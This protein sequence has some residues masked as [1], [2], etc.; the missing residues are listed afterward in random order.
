MD[1]ATPVHGDEGRTAAGLPDRA[2]PP[3][4]DGG[5]FGPRAVGP[6]EGVGEV[7]A[8]VARGLRTP[9]AVIVTAADAL[10]HLLSLE[11]PDRADVARVAD[12]ISRHSHLLR[13]LVARLGL[14]DEIG[15]GTVKLETERLE[16]TRLVEEVTSDVAAS[17]LPGRVVTVSG[18][19]PV[20]VVADRASIAEI[21]FNLL[22]NAHEYSAGEAGIEVD[23][24]TNEGHARVV[25]RDHGFGVAPGDTE[26][27]FEPYAR[28]GAHRGGIGLGLYVSRGLARAQGG[29]LSLRPAESVGSQF[30]LELPIDAACS[31]HSATV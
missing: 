4:R 6:S 30:V 27:I 28:P 9:Q 25:V 12:I 23:V 16:L 5:A 11:E 13:R 20:P 7:L 19:G 26:A 17:T 24:D 15:R 31:Q 29:D 3:R 14:A 21:V 8:L 10:T 1:A 2:H 18:N 22:S